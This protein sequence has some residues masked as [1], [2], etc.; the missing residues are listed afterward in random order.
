MLHS[1]D[2]NHVQIW[3]RGRLVDCEYGIDNIGGELLSK[4]VVEL[5][6]EGGTGD[7]EEQLAV[8]GLLE[9]ELVEELETVN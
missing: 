3:L 2:L 9:L 7:R 4:G 8:N 6:G 5:S 1:H